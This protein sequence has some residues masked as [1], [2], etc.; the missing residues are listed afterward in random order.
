VATGSR[1]LSAAPKDIAVLNVF[2]PRDKET[3][4]LSGDQA[5]YYGL[6]D[7]CT[8]LNGSVIE[9]AVIERPRRSPA[10]HTSFFINR[11]KE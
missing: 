9:G 1:V 8:G 11:G 6:C 2:V 5:V 10:F 7:E 4:K 3:Y